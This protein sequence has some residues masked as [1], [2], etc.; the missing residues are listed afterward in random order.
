MADGPLHGIRILDLTHV[1]AGPLA[2]RVLADLGAT[3]VKIEG[4]LS[5]GPRRYRG[6]LSI[7]GWIG[8]TTPLE[9]WNLN[10]VFVKLQ[11]NKQSVAIDLKAR[12]GRETFLELAREA[13][14]VIENF[15][16][17]AM[18]DLGLDYDDIAAVNPQIIYVAIPGYGKTGPYRERV[19]FGPS[20][21]GLSGLT[22]VMGYSAAEP[23]NTAMALMDPITSVN[24]TAAVLDALRRRERTGKGAYV[25]MSLHEGGVSYSGPWL[26]EHQL[27][28]KIETIGNRHPQMAPHGV[29]PCAGDDAWIAVTCRDD[30]DWQ[31][32]CGVVDGLQPHANLATRFANH[33]D[34]DEAIARWASLRSKERAARALQAV[35]VPAGPVNVTPDMTSDPQVRS[36]GFF[37]PIEPGPTPMPGS[38]IKM[39]GVGS[40]DWTPCPRLGNDN[41]AVLREW[42]D[43]DDARTAALEEAGVLVDK[44]P[45]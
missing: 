34:I 13:D 7:G 5:R 4:P 6:G 10:A 41:R 22:N 9:P 2:T 15:S 20:V 8:G 35:G 26:I 42:L 40:D 24:A 11:R 19:A 43:Y 25:E 18:P 16:A 17:R 23:R 29:Y 33:D 38:P 21:E 14:V 27:G 45:K 12:D 28:G 32:L 39:A 30:G 44:P 3:V 36:R 31:A 1:W 37:V